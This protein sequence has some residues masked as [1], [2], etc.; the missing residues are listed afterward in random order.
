MLCIKKAKHIYARKNNITLLHPEFLEVNKKAIKEIKRDTLQPKDINILFKSSNT[1]RYKQEIK[2]IYI[3]AYRFIVLTGLRRGELIG[4]KWS[5]IARDINGN[6]ILYINRSI[7]ENKEVTD[8]KTGNA[9]RKI[10]LTDNMRA[11]LK[12][13]K[14]L[15]EQLH[16]K[17]CYIFSDDGGDFIRPAQFTQRFKVYAKYNGLSRYTVHEL[18]HT[19]ISLMQN[20]IPLSV[21]KSVVGHSPKM[22]TLDTYGHEIAGDLQKA[23]NI[24]E[25]R[26]NEILKD[27]I[28]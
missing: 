24:I 26:F 12:Q 1:T 5:D 19:F 21:L 4:L 15:Q 27:R 3:Y 11:I 16:I 23:G 17:S 25:S 28:I 10:P 20:N 7:N 9:K 13:Q 18:R 6:Y 14:N 22:K 8:G 2:D